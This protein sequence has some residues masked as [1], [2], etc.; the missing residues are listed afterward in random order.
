MGEENPTVD[1]VNVE[2]SGSESKLEKNLKSKDTWLRLVFMLTYSLLIWLAGLVGIVVVVLGFLWVLFKGEINRELRQVG[3]SV[4]SYAYEIIRYLSFN[5]D[6]K[7]FPFGGRW[8]SA[9]TDE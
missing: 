5:T 9:G 1:Q 7:P 3:Q 4:A 2:D 6:E 8:P